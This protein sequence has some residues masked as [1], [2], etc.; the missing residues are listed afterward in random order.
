MCSLVTQAAKSE[1]GTAGLET[2]FQYGELCYR[3]GHLDRAIKAF[4]QTRRHPDYERV[5]T[6]KLGH[7]FSAKGG[8]MMAQLAIRQFAKALTLP[9]ATPSEEAELPAPGLGLQTKR[10]RRSTPTASYAP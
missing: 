2:Q 3:A 10:Y 9:G 4:Q 6:A 7:C 8:P 1:L 5:S